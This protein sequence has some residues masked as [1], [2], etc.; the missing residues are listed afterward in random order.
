MKKNHTKTIKTLKKRDRDNNYL[1]GTIPNWLSNHKG[2]RL[3]TLDQNELSGTIP[4][5]IVNLPNL[6]ILSLGNNKLEGTIPKNTIYKFDILDLG[7]NNLHGSIIDKSDLINKYNNITGV[8]SVIDVSRNQFS[9][10]MPDF[11]RFPKLQRSQILLFFFF[12]FFFACDFF[13]FLCVRL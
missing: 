6:D 9:G 13:I 11:T 5:S 1:N 7:G 12:G 10:F 8:G 4:E 2:L 3:I